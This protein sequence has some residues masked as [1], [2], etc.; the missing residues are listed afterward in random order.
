MDTD[1]KNFS[2]WKIRIEEFFVRI[3]W[4][5]YQCVSVQPSNIQKEK[6]C[7][8]CNFLKT[9]GYKGNDLKMEDWVVFKNNHLES[10]YVYNRHEFKKHNQKIYQL[11]QLSKSRPNKVFLSDG[12]EMPDIK[13]VHF[14]L[15]QTDLAA[16]PLIN[17]IKNERFIE[18]LIDSSEGNVSVLKNYI[19]SG[20][21]IK[22]NSHYW[23]SEC[24]NHLEELIG[25][26]FSLGKYPYLNLVCWFEV[27]C[28][29]LIVFPRVVQ[30]STHYYRQGADRIEIIPQACEIC[31]LFVIKNELIFNNLSEEIIREIYSEISF[32]YNHLM[33]VMKNFK[34]E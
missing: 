29:F 5:K 6:E 25:A 21:V 2:E 23:I 11:L 27:D 14:Y 18:P 34:L 9:N 1:F 28:W 22:S 15:R 30:K 32:N 8:I 12:F 26:S 4:E 10:L 31:G 20:V 7:V 3:I 19:R 24:Y 33:E 16:L 17:D 13:H